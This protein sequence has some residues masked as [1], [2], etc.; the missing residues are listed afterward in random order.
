M[1]IL[2]INHTFPGL[3]ASLASAFGADSR[4][5][6]LFASSYGRRQE[7]VIP[8][9]RK[10]RLSSGTSARA[11]TSSGEL[12][13]MMAAGRQALHSFEILKS[14]GFVPDMVLSS[15]SGGYA[16][17]WG[18]AFPDSFRVSWTEGMSSMPDP[19]TTMEP[20]FVRH[21]VLCRQVTDSDLVVS[22][23]AGQ[24]CLLTGNIRNAVELPYAVNTD[25]FVGGRFDTLKQDGIHL[26][27]VPELLVFAVTRAQAQSKTLSEIL[28]RLCSLRPQCHMALFCDTLATQSQM[29]AHCAELPPEL[30]RRL[31]VLGMLSLNKYRTLMTVAKAWVY[32]PGARAQAVALLEA[33]SCGAV[34]ALA[35]GSYVSPLLQDGE[36]VHLFEQQSAEDFA[37]A[38]NDRLDDTDLLQRI[39][40]GARETVVRHFAQERVL[41]MQTRFLE[42]MYQTWKEKGA[43]G[44]GSVLHMAR[45]F[46]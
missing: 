37:L 34:L 25:R 46:M 32:T 35:R 44:L 7:Q 21:L 14:S 19:T 22:L 11:R 4:H 39:R 5:E 12:E 36:N 28:A 30:A 43:S 29:R 20:A 42:T 31:H 9:V 38:L 13:S 40:Q 17:F 16:L 8:G 1:R 26:A 27:E 3:F 6:V 10:I 24:P 45:T 23:T 15:S 41:P 2:F 33:M 18:A